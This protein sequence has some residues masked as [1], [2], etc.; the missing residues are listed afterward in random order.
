[1]GKHVVHRVN[2]YTVQHSNDQQDLKAVDSWCLPVLMI[3][4]TFASVT[5]GKWGG[6]LTHELTSKFTFSL[7]SEKTLARVMAQNFTQLT[8]SACIWVIQCE[9]LKLSEKND[10]LRGKKVQGLI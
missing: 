7:R 10:S 1:V 4:V 6:E 3:T 8:T 2:K 9:A 5:D